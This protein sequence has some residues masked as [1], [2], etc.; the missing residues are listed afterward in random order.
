MPDAPPEFRTFIFVRLPKSVLLPKSA[1]LRD[2]ARE[3]H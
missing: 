1:L 3:L 2:A